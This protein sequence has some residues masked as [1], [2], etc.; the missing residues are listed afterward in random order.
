MPALANGARRREAVH[1]RHVVVEQQGVEGP[2]LRV[3]ERVERLPAIGNHERRGAL[4]LEQLLELEG[5]TT[6]V[7]PDGRQA[8]DAFVH[9]EPGT[10]DALLLDHNMPVMDGLTASRAIRQCGHPDALSV[11]I[12]ALTS[13]SFAEDVAASLDA[14]MDGHL[15]KPVRMEPVGEAIA[16]ARVRRMG[17]CA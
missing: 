17:F 8:L 3:N 2:R 5:A 13:N 16:Q 14:G 12:V 6:L 7:V 10:F 11:P 9:S 15:V 1:H 4:Q